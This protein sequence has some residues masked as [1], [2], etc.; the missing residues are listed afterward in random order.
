MP[1]STLG[2]SVKSRL[3]AS[4][5]V[6]AAVVLGTTGCT[7]I[8]PQS[9]TI[10]YAAAEGI[11]VYEMG[12]LEVRNAFIVAN[13]EGDL[14]NLVAAVIN[15]SDEMQT[16]NL[17]IGEGDSIDLSI[18]V[19]A[20]ET[21]S[22]GTDDLEPIELDGIEMVPGTDVPAQFSTDGAESHITVLPVLDGRLDYLTALV[23]RD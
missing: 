14:G 21:L 20:G 10:T 6:G 13:D 19:P 2:G 11:N 16:L 1:S 8:T 7:F 22:F 23:P 3:I 18:R 9:S 12:V 4:L 17:S 5:A 15:T